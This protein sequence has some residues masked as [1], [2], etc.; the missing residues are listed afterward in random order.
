VPIAFFPEWAARLLTNLPW[1]A[2][3][4]APIDVFLERPDAT[5]WLVRQTVWAVVLLAAG[6]VLFEAATRKLV[7]QGG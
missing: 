2:F 4:Q 7:V 6:R 1:A 3:V 5:F